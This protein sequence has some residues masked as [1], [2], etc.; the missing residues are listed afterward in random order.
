MFEYIETIKKLEEVAL[1]N[2][3]QINLFSFEELEKKVKEF[4]EKNKIVNP[5]VI[6]G[7]RFKPS[8]SIFSELP[9]QIVLERDLEYIKETLRLYESI[10]NIYIIDGDTYIA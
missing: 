2:L 1:V 7:L 9:H 8:C 3:G 10:P 5:R 4:S 6:A